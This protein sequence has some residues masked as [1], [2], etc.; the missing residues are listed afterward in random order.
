MEIKKSLPTRNVSY[1][2]SPV[3][4]SPSLKL[5]L[6]TKTDFN[7]DL[8]FSTP[9]RKAE[10]SLSLLLVMSSS[11]SG[12]D[13]GGGSWNASKPEKKHRMLSATF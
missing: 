3:T 12:S 9:F 5:C 1:I 8:N 11:T 7:N 6:V 13:D 10:V 2:P 4:M